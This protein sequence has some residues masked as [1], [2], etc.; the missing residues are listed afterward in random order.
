MKLRRVT[1]FLVALLA[2]AVVAQSVQAQKQPSAPGKHESI[3][4]SLTAEQLK[5]ALERFGRGGAD[6]PP[7]LMELLKDKIGKNGKAPI[8]EKQLKE[9]IEKNP[10]LLK[11]AEELARQMKQNGG[12][13]GMTEEQRRQFEKMLPQVEKMIPPNGVA[14]PQGGNAVP[15]GLPPMPG[16]V[17]PLPG[18]NPPGVNP[19]MPMPGGNPPALPPEPANPLNKIEPNLLNQNETPRE[20]AARAAAGLWERNI[21]P[22]DDTPAVKKALF[23]LV[24]GSEDLRDE[25]G[26]NF[27]DSLLKEAP[28]DVDGKSSL[29]ELFD[30]A[31]L[32]D[33]WDFGKLELPKLFDSDRDSDHNHDFDRG[34]QR[35]SWWSR[36]F[37]NRSPST[38]TAPRGPSGSGVSIGVPGIGGGLIPLAILAG[39]VVV[40]LLV[41]RFWG[42]SPWSRKR[43]AAGLF[44]PGWPIDPRHITTREHVVLAFEYLSVLICGPV[45]KTWTH[46]TI[47]GALADLAKTHGEAAVMLARLYELA[48]Y[49]PLTEPLTTAELAEARR[50]V[51]TLAGLDYE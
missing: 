26:N 9:L 4:G 37:G 46:N 36:N 8:D 15:P 49:A 40:A 28:T 38:P 18:N 30:G 7:E 10:E 48:R 20:K 39:L 13:K 44:G 31:A 1:G 16:M 35:E 24:E 25:N 12:A 41:W 34:P 21:G 42:V 50:L 47:A 6:F 29:S 5:A 11:R 3:S 19:A 17:E 27:W 45:A 23:E 22:L 33:S 32:G 51:C 2:A 43:A 14:P